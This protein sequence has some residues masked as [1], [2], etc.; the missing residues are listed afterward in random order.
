MLTWL[1]AAPARGQ[2]APFT[3]QPAPSPFIRT[4]SAPA[5]TLGDSVAPADTWD[6]YDTSDA[7]QPSVA[8][9]GL[10]PYGTDPYGQPTPSPFGQAIYGGPPNQRLIQQVKFEYTFLG[11]T[12]TNGSF[13]VQD[14]EVSATAT[15]PFLYNVA[16]LLITP[17]FATHWWSGPI[18]GPNLPPR[19]Y[20]LY[21]DFG[22]RPQVSPCFGLDLGV[23]PGLFTDFSQITTRSWRIQARALAI[24]TASPQIQIVGGFLYLDRN[25]L[26]WLPA[27][28]IIWTPNE[29]TRYEILFPRPKLSQRIHTFGNT[30]WWVY[31]AGEYGGGAWQ[32]DQPGVGQTNMDYNDLRAALGTEWFAFNGMKGYFEAGFVFNRQ[33]F[34]TNGTPNYYPNVTY[35]LRAGILF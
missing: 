24:F 31:L 17:G 34:F 10:N 21:L 28:G 27:G 30:D 33:L 6:P 26:K 2:Q 32:F 14:A 35:M 3:T 7:P 22:W 11:A 5:V 20:D 9:Q 18:G 29:D 4:P 13:Q 25:F 8:P 1:V 23:R 15:F 19:V 16:P 12:G